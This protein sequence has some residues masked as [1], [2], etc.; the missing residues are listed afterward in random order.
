MDL[1]ERRRRR[2]RKMNALELDERLE[3]LSLEHQQYLIERGVPPHFAATAGLRTV[4]G[5][6]AEEL[7]DLGIGLDGYGLA[8]PYGDSDYVRV[9]ADDHWISPSNRD[10]PIYVPPQAVKLV[11]DAGAELLV[12]EGAVKALCLAHHGLAAIG[13]GGV[14]TTLK[15]KHGRLRLNDSWSPVPLKGRP[16]TIV[17]DA[18]R[19]FN[20]DVARAEA[21][22]AQALELE[23]AQV[24]VTALPSL[25]DDEDPGPDDYVAREGLDALQLV[26]DDRVP[27][28]P[29]ARL[30]AALGGDGKDDQV[31]AAELLKDLP[32][33]S[34]VLHAP[35]ADQGLVKTR[36]VR[37]GLQATTFNQALAEVREMEL[38]AARFGAADRLDHYVVDDGHL[39]Y[40]SGDRFV[41][42][43]NF[44]PEIVAVDH[45][46]EEGIRTFRV[47]A[48]LH[49]G[50]ALAEVCVEPQELES[51]S[52]PSKKWGHG[53]VLSPRSDAPRRLQNALHQRSRPETITVY[54][55]TGWIRLTEGLRFL[56]RGG[57]LGG[58]AERVEVHLDANLTK[59]ELPDPPVDIE[60]AIRVALDLV[61][62]APKKITLALLAAAFSAPLREALRLDGT[63]FLEG[64][65]GT[66]K[67]EVASLIQGFFGPFERTSLPLSWNDTKASIEHR[68]N[69]MADVVATIDDYAPAAREARDPHR[70]KAEVVLR[71]AGNLSSRGRMT[72]TLEARRNRPCRALILV[73]GEHPP[74]DSSILPRM[75]VLHMKKGDVR[76]DALTSLQERRSRLPHAMSAFLYWLI[77]RMEGL[78][79][80][81]PYRRREFASQLH[82]AEVHLRTP[83]LLG[84]L[85]AGLEL[86]YQ[87]AEELGVLGD[88]GARERIEEAV[89]VFREVGADQA[90]VVEG[91]D[92]V[93]R[94]LKRLKELLLKGEVRLAE[95]RGEDLKGAVGWRSGEEVL[96]LP[97]LVHEAIAASMKR[98]GENIVISASAFG[99]GLRDKGL[100][101][102]SN[103]THVC[104]KR[105][106]GPGRQSTRVLVL[107]AS[108]LEEADGAERGDGD[109]DGEAP[110]SKVRFLGRRPQEVPA[111]RS[112]AT[113][114][115]K[116]KNQ[117]S[118]QYPHSKKRR[119]A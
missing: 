18:G 72:S 60:D 88:V 106:V 70:E 100:L 116:G 1:W 109:G 81:L 79:D 4:D 57:L 40:W 110:R 115:K 73:T 33:A 62:V 39:G 87:F 30:D 90:T 15:S 55:R 107:R 64:P 114:R 101:M 5:D 14:A 54:T 11:E 85:L 98:G 89:E 52:W 108:A 13:L 16:V 71:S 103:E 91:A 58:K 29:I 63:I 104:A 19:A 8:V 61:D 78:E 47:A 93:L 82:Q 36:L 83:E 96:L 44:V 32:F 25:D 77:D 23:G 24:S 37:T 92:H 86:F 69:V 45:R 94:A 42:V 34:S 119:G 28:N 48:V 46:P 51:W 65:T 80:R 35:A 20:P 68:L 97:D 31:V 76:L 2:R 102:P 50:R 75:L 9:R 74:S 84:G 66:M 113:A 118:P 10:V 38:A 21:R 27:A 7:L 17:F 22:L 6:E 3:Q 41:V 67:S 112:S 59:L 105:R 99:R 111:G 12:V 49:D 117:P 56:H 53:P 26:L 43:S 95:H